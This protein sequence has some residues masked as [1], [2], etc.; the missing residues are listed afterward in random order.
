MSVE[1]IRGWWRSE[2]RDLYSPARVLLIISEGG[3]NNGSWLRVWKLEL[4]KLA[5]QTG[6]SISVCHLPPRGEPLRDNETV[7][8]PISRTATAKGLKVTC[9]LDQRRY[10]AGRKVTVDEMKSVN[11][12]QNRFHGEWHY[13]IHPSKQLTELLPLFIDDA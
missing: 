7:V 4:Q 8:N 12:T 9:R 11:L 5:N 13:T 2:G 1:S 3:G 10:P 6:L